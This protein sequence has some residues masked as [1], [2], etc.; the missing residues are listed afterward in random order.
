M[1]RAIRQTVTPAADGAPRHSVLVVDDSRVQLRVL[2]ALLGKM[3]Y[4]VSEAESAEDALAQCARRHPDMV[5]S[6]WM[7]PGMT[8]PEFCQALRRATPNHYSY[9]ILLTAKSAKE[10]IAEG[11]NAGADD[12]L[13]KPVNQSELRA[14]L[15]A[16]TRIL[17]MQ[18]E[19]QAKNQVITQALSELKQVYDGIEHDL[20]HA[21]ALQQSLVPDRTRDFGAA[22][23]SLLFQ[24]CG[25]VGG[26][27][28]G[29]FSPGPGQVGF[30]NLDVSGH[31]IASALVSAR[32]AS[33]FSG[34]L[35]EQNIALCAGKDGAIELRR[36]CKVAEVLNAR[37]LQD[38]GMMEYFTI[39]YATADL[40]TGAIQMV[41]AGHP[42]PLLLRA[43]GR[44][45]FVGS[46]GMPIGLMPDPIYKSVP[47]QL[48]PGD[49]LLIY[50]DGMTE[51][52]QKD[53]S[54]LDGA[55]LLALVREVPE[56]KSGPEYLDD[57]YWR[58]CALR[59]R[60]NPH[61]DDISAVLFERP[62]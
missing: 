24:P 30:Y 41:Q 56:T 21:R 26:D 17:A 6:D 36:P 8:G 42:P 20:T 15:A 61:D 35:P 38:Q 7:M 55:G 25:H 47:I 60:D 40:N 18:E 23:I 11:L 12:F 14:R 9:F 5:I 19:L 54:A 34:D 37:M 27:L 13:T 4:A 22:R 62:A 50:S 32:I 31:G 1:P 28:V 59:D 44:A 10:E 51:L 45:E 48:G 52:M 57:L 58:L 46:G 29:L 33:Y 39:A 16:G 53:G 43:D 49:R 2:S 3:G